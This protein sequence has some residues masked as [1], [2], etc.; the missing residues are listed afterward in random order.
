M[1]IYIYNS[2]WSTNKVVV[3]VMLLII[4]RLFRYSDRERV[5]KCGRRLKTQTSRCLKIFQRSYTN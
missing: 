2:M 5:F 4:A 1:Y 3:V